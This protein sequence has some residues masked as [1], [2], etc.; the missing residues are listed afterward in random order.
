MVYVNTGA[1]VVGVKLSRWP[2]PQDPVMLTATL[3][4]FDAITRHL[5]ASG[6]RGKPPT[7]T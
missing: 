1:N 2:V 3:R 6:R 7:L 4:A 5:A